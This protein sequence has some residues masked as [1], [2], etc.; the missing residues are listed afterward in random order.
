MSEILFYFYRV[1]LTFFTAVIS[2]S[3]QLQRYLP[4]YMLHAT[5]NKTRAEIFTRTPQAEVF[6]PSLREFIISDMNGPGPSSEINILHV[7]T[8]NFRQLILI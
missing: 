2:L 3:W 5:A 1:H 6:I 4:Y 8:A 7:P